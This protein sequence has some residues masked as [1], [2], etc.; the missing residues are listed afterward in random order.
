MTR[1]C[2]V[3][4]LIEQE[5]YFG[6]HAP[7]QVGKT[8]ALLSL[9]QELTVEGQYAATLVSM[10][11]GAAFPK[12]VGAAEAAV[13]DAWGDAI[14][15]QPAAALAPHWRPGPP[16]PPGPWRSRRLFQPSGWRPGT[17]PARRRK[18]VFGANLDRRL[19]PA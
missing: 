19:A 16:A 10:E 12:D 18:R 6:L 3:R 14:L 15:K 2:V 9:A 4:R 5:S 7:R 17:L 13:L 11:V 8:T 1:P